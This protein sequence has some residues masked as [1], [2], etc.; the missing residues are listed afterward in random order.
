MGH[1]CP[2]QADPA[3]LFHQGPPAHRTRFY[4]KDPDTHIEAIFGCA[5]TGTDGGA[6]LQRFH[7]AR[8]IGERKTSPTHA[9]LDR[10]TCGARS[11][12]LF[13]DDMLWR[14]KLTFASSRSPAS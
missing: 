6:G 1:G 7:D 9:S 3:R 10:C 11:G 14:P 5:A 2:C 13:S 8:I 4:L 12:A